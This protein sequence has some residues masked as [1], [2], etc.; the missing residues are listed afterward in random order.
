MNADDATGLTRRF[1]IQLAGAIVA[2]PSVSVEASTS[3]K[4]G[5]SPA[6]VKSFGA[7]GDGSTDDTAAIQAG[8]NYVHSIGGGTLY[9]PEGKYKT[10]SFLAVH[11]HTIIR[12]AGRRA[13]IITGSH[14]GGGGTNAAES[15]RN[16]SIL[17][18]ASPINTTGD[19]YISIHD[20]WVTNSNP[21]NVGAGFYQQSGDTIT[22]RDCLFSGSK[23]GVIFDQTEDATIICC[24]L[25]SGVARGAGLWLVNGPGLM[26]GAE[27]G[28]TGSVTLI[29]NHYN[30]PSTSYGIIDDG[31]PQH[32][33]IGG[34]FNGGVVGY[35]TAGATPVLLLNPY[36]E[37]QTDSCIAMS[38]TS[39]FG[40]TTTGGSIVELA[41]GFFS[42]GAHPAIRCHASAGSLLLS[43][44]FYNGAM[45]PIDGAANLFQTILSGYSNL[46]GLPFT[47]SR[48][49][50]GG[51]YVDLAKLALNARGALI[52]EGL[53]VDGSAGL[54]Y[55]TGAGGAATQVN[56]RSTDVT[57][58]KSC[59][60]IT[61]C[62]TTTRAGQVSTFTVRNS[63][64]G[65]ADVIHLNQQSA[66]AGGPY[67]LSVTAVAVGSFNISVYT[68]VA[69]RVPDAPVIN[70]AV[71][72]A[73]AE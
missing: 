70:F 54:G 63:T 47:D 2:A 10:S 29:E 24:E 55:A 18:N 56:S 8:L 53:L 25:G 19:G 26:P 58:N 15:A 60:Q 32:M 22:I 34:D 42:A 31:G 44:G 4:T 41:G 16:G 33:I 40:L 48:T 66:T 68:P 52:L 9:F 11:P 17:Y 51:P 64:V 12:G 38:G 43:G 49:T 39:S 73:V 13:S 37:G 36:F 71:I 20:L 14:A 62:S 3:A 21:A 50:Q 57:I 72:K 1:A 35:L 28:F 27:T 67:I 69:V 61:L 23:Y 46:T 45:S 59:G 6:N 65:R 30:V 5:A 7:Q